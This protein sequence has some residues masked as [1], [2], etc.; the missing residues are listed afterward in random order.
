MIEDHLTDIEIQQLAFD[1]DRRNAVFAAH[2]DACQ[3]CAARLEFYKEHFSSLKLMPRPAFD[4]DLSGA[5]LN[6][7]KTKSKFPVR[8]VQLLLFLGLA[9]GISFI[10]HWLFT[11]YLHEL[12]TGFSYMLI[13][14]LLAAILSFLCFQLWDIWRKY[15]QKMNALNLY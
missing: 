6:Q 15:Q 8:I 12:F 13:F 10:A 5:V 3:D 1:P 2:L 11:K 14:L 9:T 7:I 4:F